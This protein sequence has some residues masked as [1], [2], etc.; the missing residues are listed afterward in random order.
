MQRRN[1]IKVENHARQ[2]GSMQK[3]LIKQAKLDENKSKQIMQVEMTRYNDKRT[4]ETKTK[5]KRVG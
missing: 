4:R 1:K 5:I 3:T 2:E